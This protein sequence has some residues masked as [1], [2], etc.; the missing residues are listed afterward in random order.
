MVGVDWTRT[1]AFARH[2]GHGNSYVGRDLLEQRAGQYGLRITFF[3]EAE[4]AGDPL[5]SSL[6]VWCVADA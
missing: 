2:D 5:Y 6:C 3:A 4:I 1:E